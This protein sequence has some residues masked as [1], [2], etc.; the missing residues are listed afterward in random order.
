MADAHERDEHEGGGSFMMGLLT[1]TVLGAGLGIL[2]APKSGRE[3]RHDIGEQASSLGRS[4]SE[5]FR[6]VSDAAGQ[7]VGRVRET[8]GHTVA[9]REVIEGSGA[10]VTEGP[11]TSAGGP[12]GAGPAGTSTYPGT[13][14]R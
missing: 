5:G 4:A 9:A 12:E 8:G 1:G 14:E 3:L 13:T 2:L 10:G 7:V 6:R 11:A